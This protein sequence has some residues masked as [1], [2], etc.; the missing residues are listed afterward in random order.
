[1]ELLVLAAGRGSRFKNKG[2]TVPKPLF[3]FDEKP[4]FWWAVKSA[5]SSGMVTAIHFAVLEEHIS[6][7]HLDEEIKKYFPKAKLHMFKTVTSGAAETAMELVRGLNTSNPIGVLDCDLAFEFKDT[8]KLATLLGSSDVLISTFKSDSPA[9]SYVRYDQDM[10]II[11]TV[12]KKVVSEDAIAGFYMFANAELFLSY[13][14]L[15]KNNCSYNELYVSGLIDLIINDEK[16][17]NTIEIEP[18]VSFGTPAEVSNI[19]PGQ[20]NE[21]SWRKE[22]I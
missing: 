3:M 9:Y 5:I 11:G 6:D 20:I 15:Y 10:K 19:T 14:S 8:E 4:L 2:I 22:Y 7:Y 13:Y 18:H 1:M 21:L 12:E 16:N 17:V